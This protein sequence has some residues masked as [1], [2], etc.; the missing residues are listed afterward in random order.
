MTSE[1]LTSAT[2][3]DVMMCVSSQPSYTSSS[4][5]SGS[6]SS[7]SD[8]ITTTTWNAGECAQRH[9]QAGSSATPRF[10]LCGVRQDDDITLIHSHGFHCLQVGT[11]STPTPGVSPPL[12]TI[13]T[14]TRVTQT[15]GNESENS[16]T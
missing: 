6:C 2:G 1:S 13:A 8:S 11:L 16:T 10:T 9:L 14:A 15:H 12:T 3:S 4:V 5:T 7:T